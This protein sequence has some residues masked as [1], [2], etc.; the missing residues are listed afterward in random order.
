MSDLHPTVE[1]SRLREMTLDPRAFR[2]R[3]ARLEFH[4]D[5]LVGFGQSKEA[6]PSDFANGEYS[7]RGDFSVVVRSP[8]VLG[9]A[10]PGLL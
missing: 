5:D 3:M 2:H 8:R 4:E 6:Q 7:E 1:P 10:E 9:R